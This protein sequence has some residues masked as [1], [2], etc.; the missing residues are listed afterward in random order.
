[1][2]ISCELDAD[3]SGIHCKE[4]RCPFEEEQNSISLTIYIHNFSVLEAYRKSFYLRDIGKWLYFVSYALFS[5]IYH[6]SYWE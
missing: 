3:G 2:N 6:F 5:S 4:N 1:M